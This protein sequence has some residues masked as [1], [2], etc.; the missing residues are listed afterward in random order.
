M[1]IMKLMNPNNFG[2]KQL[3]ENCRQL[4]INELLRL[5]NRRIKEELLNS[6]VETQQVDINFTTTKTGFGGIRFWFECP[7]CQK[8]KGVLYIHPISQ[9]LGC[10]GCLNLDYRKRRYKG[11]IEAKQLA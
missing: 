8:R 9:D 11:M 5:Y 2:K 4:R 7:I 1:G 3:V 10:R 6:T